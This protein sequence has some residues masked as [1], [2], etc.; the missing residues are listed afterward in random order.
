MGAPRHSSQPNAPSFLFSTCWHCLGNLRRWQDGRARQAAG[1][2]YGSVSGNECNQPP[3]VLPGPICYPPAER[4]QLLNSPF[5]EPR[6]GNSRIFPP[7]GDPFP[8][9]IQPVRSP[10]V[11]CPAAII[12]NHLPPGYKWPRFW[13]I[14][15]QLAVQRQ[16][17]HTYSVQHPPNVSTLSHHP[18]PFNGK[19]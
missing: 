1:R 9:P 8:C 12:E 10:P 19:T 17:P 3:P 14:P 5:V 7:N 15:F 18:L 16:L 11:F 13:S 2:F 4:F 6:H